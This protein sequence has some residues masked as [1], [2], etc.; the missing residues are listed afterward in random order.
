MISGSSWWILLHASFMHLRRLIIR[1]ILSP[2]SLITVLLLEPIT[3]R[4]CWHTGH[5]LF[6]L[7]RT[8]NSQLLVPFQHKLWYNNHTSNVVRILPDARSRK[9]W[10]RED[11]FLPST[12]I[13]GHYIRLFTDIQVRLVSAIFP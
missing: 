9:L 1:I 2:S 7:L 4:D 11:L 13:Y 6:S 10:A 3:L 5:M 8:K 12:Y